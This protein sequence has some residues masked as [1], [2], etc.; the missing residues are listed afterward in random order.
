MRWRAAGGFGRS[1]TARAQRGITLL[2]ALIFLLVFALMAAAALNSTLTSGQAIGNMQWRNE[3]IA[4]ANDAIDQVLS[5]TDFATNTNNFTA[6]VNATPYQVDINGDGVSDI[7]VNF[8]AV[9]FD[10]GPAV[11]GPQCLRFRSIPLTALSPTAPNDIGCF[12]SSSAENSGLGNVADPNDPTNTSTLAFAAGQSICANTEWAIP[13]RATDAVTNTSVD[14]MQG[15]GVRVF[16]SD[17]MNF[18][19]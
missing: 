10:N 14:V 5:T 13:V 1:A 17:A 4:A 8:P 18:C 6:Q 19:E 15:A 3:A 12:G 11:A 9:S 7:L 16:I 2:V